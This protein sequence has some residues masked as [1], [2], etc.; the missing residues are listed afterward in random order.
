MNEAQIALARRLYLARRML[1]E[2]IE[3]AKNA[4]DLARMRA[5]LALDHAVELVVATLLS[6]LRIDVKPKT[7][8]P[9]M[10]RAL[11]NEREALKSHLMPIV[12]LHNR[13]NAVQ[14][15]GLVPS[16]E[17]VRLQAVYAEGF[18]R[19]SVREVENKEL[20]E[21]SL[22]SLIVNDRE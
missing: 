1:S 10:L 7:F 13:R 8:L 3:D 6:E 21:I 5:I 4:S 17:E 18:V 16:T 20:E 22:A 15:E 2:G 11:C 9:E 14:H 19:D 12:T